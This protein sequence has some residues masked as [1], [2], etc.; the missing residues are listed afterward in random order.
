MRS[1]CFYEGEDWPRAVRFARAVATFRPGDE[2]DVA[3]S[4]LAATACPSLR[5]GRRVA[6]VVEAVCP[7]RYCGIGKLGV[8]RD[9]EESRRCYSFPKAVSVARLV[10][11]VMPEL[12]HHT[13]LGVNRKVLTS[14]PIGKACAAP[15]RASRRG[16]MHPFDIFAQRASVRSRPGDAHRCNDHPAAGG[17]SGRA[18]CTSDGG[19]AHRAPS[20]AVP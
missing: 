13:V 15:S 17:P 5:R 18:G 11:S 2:L 8:R 7:C 4:C 12:F 3:R 9:P 20:T 16:L 14:P 10:G 1:R 6:H 19:A